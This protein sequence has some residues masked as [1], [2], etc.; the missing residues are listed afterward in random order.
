MLNSP[1]HC[2]GYHSKCS[3]DFC[4]TA[5]ELSQLTVSPSSSGC[6]DGNSSGGDDGNS[7]GGDDGNSSGG[8]DGNS[9]SGDDMMDTSSEGYNSSNALADQQ[10][11]LEDAAMELQQEWNDATDDTNF[12][13]V[14]T[15]PAAT[16]TTPTA[17]EEAIICDVQRILGKLVGKASQL[18]GI[19]CCKTIQ[20]FIQYFI[21]NCTTNL[22]ECWMHIRTKSDGGKQINRIQCGSWEGRCTGAGLRLNEGPVWG[23]TCW[24]KVVLVPANTVYK[25]Y[26][27]TLTRV[28]DQDRKRKS[29]QQAK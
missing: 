15:V 27:T 20:W 3:V 16:T 17:Q 1:L 10:D 4:T 28:V 24:E 14:K 6:D 26:T 13:A 23:P 8:D 11:D 21:G 2:F 7:S 25:S 18:L 9:S 12:E 19:C 22:A 29:S 5:K